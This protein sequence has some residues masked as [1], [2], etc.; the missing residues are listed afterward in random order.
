[1]V[2]FYAMLFFMKETSIQFACAKYLRENKIM[3][4]HVPNESDRSARNA[5]RLVAMGMTSGVPDLC[6]M[7]KNGTMVFVELKVPPNKESDKQKR[8]RE[9]ATQKGFECHVLVAQSEDEAVEALSKILAG[10]T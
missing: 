6:I 9:Q 5:A 2:F 3:F 10:R 7:L 4:F 8:W 1:M